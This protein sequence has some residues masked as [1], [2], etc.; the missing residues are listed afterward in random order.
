MTPRGHRPAR[1]HAARGSGTLGAPARCVARS[2]VAL[3][4]TFFLRH[5]GSFPCVS[6]NPIVTLN[7]PHAAIETSA[8]RGRTQKHRTRKDAGAVQHAQR[9]PQTS[10]WCLSLI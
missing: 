8:R 6:L 2:P 1:L 9:A 5:R 3:L 7:R 10:N 4:H